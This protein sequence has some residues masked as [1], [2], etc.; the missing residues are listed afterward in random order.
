MTIAASS[1]TMT[2]RLDGKVALVTGASQGIGK[3]I[4]LQ[5]AE[6][7]AD[8]VVAHFPSPSDKARA[9]AVVNA[10]E[11][12][13]RRALAVAIDVT[14][15]KSV[16]DAVEEA[17]AHVAGID[18]LVNN[19]GA[20]QRGIGL[21]TTGSD[22]DNCFDVSVKGAWN[23]TRAVPATLKAR[24]GARIINISSGAGRRGQA[25]FPAHCAAKAALLSLTQSMALALA[26]D[27]IN[28][29]AICP[30]A[31]VT[32]TSEDWAEMFSRHVSGLGEK[33]TAE[34]I[35]R[36][37]ERSIPLRRLQSVEDIAEAVLFFASP[38]AENIT[39]QALNVDG[40]LLMN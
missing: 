14:D 36:R 29:N 16:T 32:K 35:F 2:S 26:T 20:M 5:L 38:A 34:G 28:V 10:I 39:G 37:V 24:G 21:E 15:E 3:A 13:N 12:F 11:A 17:S 25:E 22:F 33:V 30:G 27:N 4:A 9:L 6:A 40:G 19:A 31:I 18:I 1:G 7:G 8:V 23:L